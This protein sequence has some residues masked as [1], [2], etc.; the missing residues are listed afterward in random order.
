MSQNCLEAGKENSRKMGGGA[1]R[2]RRWDRK[3]NNNVWRGTGNVSLFAV[4][5]E[6]TTDGWIAAVV[7]D[8]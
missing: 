2:A 4:E 8:F 3:W 6:R 7:P 5:G 1:A